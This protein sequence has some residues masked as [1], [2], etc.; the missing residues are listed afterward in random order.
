MGRATDAVGGYGERVAV[1]HLVAQG[2]YLVERNWRCSDGELDAILRD[3][4][5]Q[6][7][8]EVKPRRGDGY[9][10]PAEAVGWRKVRRLRRLAAR[11]LAE[12]PA[13]GVDVRFDVVSVWPQ[14]RGP[15]R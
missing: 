8:V 5:V 14:R 13:G 15:A 9:G 4:D 7:V 10:T 11:W 3:G 1:A 2:M 6:V 12:H